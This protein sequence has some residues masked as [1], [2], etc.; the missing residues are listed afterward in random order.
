[1]KK[2]KDRLF[3]IAIVIAVIGGFIYANVTGIDHIEDTNGPDDYS[4][5]TITA[6]EIVGTGVKRAR[7]GPHTK[8]SK[9]HFMG[10]TS[11]S[12]TT[13]YSKEFSGIHLVETWNLFWNSDLALN[14]YE[15]EVTG[16]NFMMCL[17]HDG[18][19]VATIEPSEDGHVY[20]EMRDLEDG[21]YDLYLVGESAAFSF[22]THD[23]D[24]Q[25]GG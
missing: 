15:Y 17:V 1:M 22:V 2:L 4:L 6:E 9:T 3:A 24:G 7:G 8:E 19:I 12:G 5:A 20:F 21:T 14:F 18:E 13:F 25:L 10:I 16:G 11:S 23:F